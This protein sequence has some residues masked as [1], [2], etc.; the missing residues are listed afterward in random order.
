MIYCWILYVI[1]KK[2]V[3]LYDHYGMI[4]C[5]GICSRVGL[6]PS[7]ALVPCSCYGRHGNLLLLD[8]C[9]T[10]IT[11]A[12]CAYANVQYD[13]YLALRPIHCTGVCNIFTTNMLLSSSPSERIRSPFPFHD[14][15]RGRECMKMN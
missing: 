13:N 2:A 10:F 9:N 5:G 14:M 15:P 12:L 6:S 3:G 1:R 8:A 11:S 7:Y 4:Y